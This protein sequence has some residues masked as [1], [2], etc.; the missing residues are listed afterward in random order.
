MSRKKR[1][2]RHVH[3]STVS[4]YVNYIILITPNIYFICKKIDYT[5]MFAIR[6]YHFMLII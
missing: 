5:D 4:F 3:N 2:Y 6:Q 1:L